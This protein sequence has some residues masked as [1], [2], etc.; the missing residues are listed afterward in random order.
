[1]QVTR[2]EALGGDN[3]SLRQ[4]VDA[5]F[6]RK[7][8]LKAVQSMLRDEFGVELS[9]GA[10]YKY[11]KKWEAEIERI[12]EEKYHY[13]AIAQVIG[14]D[15]L[16]CLARARLWE[17]TKVLPPELLIK[18]VQ[19]GNEKAKIEIASID[20]ENQSR[21]LAAKLKD[22]ERERA[23]Q[24][25]DV[26]QALNAAEPEVAVQRLRGF[27]GLGPDTPPVQVTVTAKPL[28]LGDGNTRSE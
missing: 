10:I 27:F 24:R 9:Q 20:L 14:E 1:M 26:A 11:R 19:I 18:L 25:K 8:T 4:R 12:Q 22:V 7:K 17:A 2:I 28:A 21:E 5:M 16:D 3:R 15:G 6:E 13:K 23:Q